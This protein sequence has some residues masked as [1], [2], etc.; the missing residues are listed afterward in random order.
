M[1]MFGLFAGLALAW[2][3]RE[4]QAHKRLIILAA[5][6]LMDPSIGR[7]PI[8]ALAQ[9]PDFSFWLKLIL[10]LVPLMVWDVITLRRLHWATLLGAIVLIAEGLLRGP[11]GATPQWLAFAKW[12]TGLAG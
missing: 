10:F 11:I 4:P 12:A 6:V 5:I 7:W 3:R 8:D 9:I 1:V 2:R